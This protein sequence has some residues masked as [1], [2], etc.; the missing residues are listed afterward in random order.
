MKKTLIA[1]SC[2][3][4]L[5]SFS[6][7]SN[8]LNND[9]QEEDLSLEFYEIKID[10]VLKTKKFLDKDP[11]FIIKNYYENVLPIIKDSEINFT[12][13][14]DLKLK[15]E[16]IIKTTQE[17]KIDA[18]KPKTELSVKYTEITNDEI[19]RGI[20]AFVI[21]KKPRTITFDG[22]SGYDMCR[23]LYLDNE[24]EYRPELT[25]SL[26]ISFNK[27]SILE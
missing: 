1:A 10:K 26:T 15:H 6:S 8:T 21:D 18:T 13:S 9:I 14:S 19:E 27:F 23:D 3:L 22:Q 2:L 4:S 12:I 25:C 20:N 7:Y 24:I 16:P 17:F 5:I 11:V